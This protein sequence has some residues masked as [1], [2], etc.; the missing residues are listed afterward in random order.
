MSTVFLV[1]VALIFAPIALAIAV[2]AL[3]VIVGIAAMAYL[4]AFGLVFPKC[5]EYRDR[6]FDAGPFW[7]LD[8]IS[9][10]RL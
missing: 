5:R 3:S 8:L 2:A 1:I 6:L 4:T 9:Q 7:L 10:G